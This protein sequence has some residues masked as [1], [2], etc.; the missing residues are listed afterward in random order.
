[1]PKSVT[2]LSAIISSK[3]FEDQFSSWSMQ[4]SDLIAKT[5]ELQKLIVIFGNG[6]SAA[7]AQHWAA[8]LICTYKSRSRQPY[9]ALALTTDSSIL[10]AWSNDFN[11]ATVF[12]RQ[13]EAY[14]FLLG[15][16]IGMSTSGRSLNVLNALN[17]A[18]NLDSRTVLISGSS[19]ILREE[20]DIHVR[21]PTTDTPT[22]QTLTQMLYHEVC[23]NLE[24]L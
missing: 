15:L 16:A 18:R 5:N 7:D 9:P 13:V 23:Q 20:F 19:A 8:E 3:G 12:Q 14:K 2:Y 6:G 10:T 4:I 17:K 1:M 21:F 22:I 24:I 11:F